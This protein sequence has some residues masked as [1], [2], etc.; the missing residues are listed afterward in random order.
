MA[1]PR[2]PRLL[3]VTK[4]QAAALQAAFLAETRDVG[5]A[6][7]FTNTYVD[8][9][10]VEWAV[11]SASWTQHQLDI[12]DRVLARPAIA[13]ARLGGAVKSHDGEAREKMVEWKLSPKGMEK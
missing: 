2:F 5:W 9:K 13:L 10:G 6:S 7:M 11:A 8:D 12:I 1:V 4:A 3:T